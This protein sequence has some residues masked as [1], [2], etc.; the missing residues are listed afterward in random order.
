MNETATNA[1]A[2]EHSERKNASTIITSAPT[3]GVV[4]RPVNTLCGHERLHRGGERGA[5]HDELAHQQQIGG[6]WSTN[7][8][9]AAVVVVVVLVRRGLQT[10]RAGDQRAGAD[11]HQQ[12]ERGAPEHHLQR[13]AAA[14]GD[15]GG[16]QHDRVDDR[17]GE[18]ERDARG[19]VD[20]AQDQPARDR[21]AAALADRHRHPGERDAGDLQ[22]QR[23]ARD[24]GEPALGHED[25][26]RRRDARAEE[27]ERQRLD[28][29]RG[30][31]D[32]ERLHAVELADAE[33]R[34]PPRITA[35]TSASALTASSAVATRGV[36]RRR[37]AA[38]PA[39]AARTRIE[40][41]GSARPSSRT[42]GSSDCVRSTASSVTANSAAHSAA[43]ATRGIRRSAAP[44][45][46]NGAQL[47]RWN[48]R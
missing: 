11:R 42:S 12:A 7:D 20:A 34:G 3:N 14:V 47:Q 10:A 8:A 27:D 33:E 21:D 48:G 30:A 44:S 26:D 13:A 29:D 22:R 2:S 45:T 19:G 43:P 31:D 35:A 16:E 6:R 46:T 17:R 37:C 23:E 15:G 28:G 40:I 4:S 36:P 24:G 5:E 39:T 1:S 38:K 25:L 41:P 32:Q 18:H 9:G